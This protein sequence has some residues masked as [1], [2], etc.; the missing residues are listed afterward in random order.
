MQVFR[1]LTINDVALTPYPFKRELS[2]QSYLIDNESVLG[3]D[4]GNYADVE[5]IDAEVALIDGQQSKDKDGRADI[6][7]TYGAETIGICELKNVQLTFEHLQQLGDYIKVRHKILEKYPSAID[8][9]VVSTPNWVGVLIGPSIEPELERAIRA[10]EITC[11]GVPIAALIVQ[12]YKGS[13][14]SVIVSTD[15]YFVPPGK[16]NY[17]KY[18]FEG[19]VLDKSNLALQLAKAYLRDHPNVTLAQF[20]ASFPK[21]INKS[22]DFVATLEFAQ[23]MLNHKPY[24]RFH[25]NENSQL[26][27]A[28]CTAVVTNQWGIKNIDSLLKRAQELGF[29]ITPVSP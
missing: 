3:L 26:K 20:Q 27:L 10:G 23:E 28:D 21:S 2:L 8:R 17:T 14:G 24:K 7:V 18:M 6:V 29:Q 5:I 25:M 12:R 1:H 16:K 11:D 19:Q 4:R 22:F 15:T 9:E 13:D